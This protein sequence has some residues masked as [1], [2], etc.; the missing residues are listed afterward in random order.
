MDKKTELAAMHGEELPAGLTL[1]G[2]KYYIAMRSLYGDYNSG[3]ITKER[4]AKEKAQLQRTYA[5]ERSKE[6]FLARDALALSERIN[7][8]AENF[9]KDPS[10]ETANAFYAAIFNLANSWREKKD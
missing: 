7:Q 6:E 10:V 8:A 2:Q 3:R 5:E 9:R 1:A 4:A